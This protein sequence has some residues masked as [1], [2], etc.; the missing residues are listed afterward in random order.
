MGRDSADI[1]R[2]DQHRG[3]VTEGRRD[4]QVG[5]CL[6]DTY[7]LLGDFCLRLWFQVQVGGADREGG[8]GHE[9]VGSVAYMGELGFREGPCSVMGV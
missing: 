8:W 3:L 6:H 7:S 1:Q 5:S 2:H 9:R 4:A